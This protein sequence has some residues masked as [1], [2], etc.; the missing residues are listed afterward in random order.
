MYAGLALGVLAWL[1]TA[2]AVKAGKPWARP[3]A[4]VVF[5]LGTS[6]GLTGLLSKDTSGATGL[7]S[8]LGWAGMIPC[9]AGVV[10]VAQLWRRP[11]PT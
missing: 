7:P 6:V 3:A 2:W 11:R 9:L 8:A 10:A 1:A 5:M 4:T